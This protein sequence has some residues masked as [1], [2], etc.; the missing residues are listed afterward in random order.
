MTPPTSMDRVLATIGHREPDR[1]PLLMTTT[2]HGARVLGLSIEEYFSRASHVVEGQLRMR[3]R[4]GSDFFYA[5][6]HAALELEAWGAE[7]IFSEEG[8]PNAGAPIVRKPTDITALEPPDPERT[9]CT[10]RV[11]EAIAALAAEARGEVPIAGFVVSPFSLPVMQLGFEGYLN[12][13]YEEPALFDRLMRINE[14]FCVR[15]ANAQ[16]AAGATA[17]AYFDPVASP[18]ITTPDAYRRFGKPVATRTLA[19]IRGPTATHLA[20]GLCLPIVDDL[21]ETG[22]GMVGVSA[23]E[24]LAS[25]KAS[26]AGRLTVVGNLNGITMRRWTAEQAEAEV[27]AAGP[28]GGFILADNHGEIPWQVPEEVLDAIGAAVREWGRYPLDWLD[29]GEA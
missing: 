27:A 5:A 17:I 20:S 7:V 29:R 1:V 13:T 11:L 4:Y 8:P 16:L 14:E 23:L 18:T 15:F 2:M 19:R 6:F 26:C 25:I 28:G 12:L 24:D 9:P 3:E 21:V 22:T 10:V